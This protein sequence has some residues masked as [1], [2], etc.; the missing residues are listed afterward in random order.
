[1]IDYESI[2]SDL[3]LTPKKAHELMPE[4]EISRWR[5]IFKCIRNESGLTNT[6]QDDL[7][8]LIDLVQNK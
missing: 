2:I 8:R 7:D 5:I 1:M 4:I 6:R 3:G